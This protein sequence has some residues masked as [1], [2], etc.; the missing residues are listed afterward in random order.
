[1]DLKELRELHELQKRLDYRFCHNKLLETALTHSS[2]VNENK[3]NYEENNE[4]LEF[5]GDALLDAIISEYFFERYPKAQEGFLTKERAALVCEDSLFE[6]GNRIGL[7]NFLRLGRG[8]EKNGGRT[9]KSM[10][11]DAVEAVIGAVFLDGGWKATRK[12]ALG[13]LGHKID[14]A[15]SGALMIEDYKSMVQEKLQSAG[16]TD[17][18]Y[19]LAWSEGPDHDKTFHVDLMINGRTRASGVGKSKKKAEQAA[20]E[21]LYE[22]GE[23]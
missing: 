1:M 5:L 11:A 18:K 14:Q 13:M 20:A 12:V 7:G 15:E 23:L 8:E 10:I 16:Y 22:S 6:C 4:R 17:I 9:R 21:K 3:L 2:Y 19:V